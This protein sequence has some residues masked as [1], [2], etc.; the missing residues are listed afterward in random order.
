MR[1]RAAL[2]RHQRQVDA[3]SVR[4]AIAS[5]GCACF[6][7]SACTWPAWACSGSAF[8]W[9]AFWSRSRLYAVRMFAI[10][11]FYHRYFSHKAFRTSRPVQFVFAVLGAASVQRGP[12]WWA[13]HH[14]HHHRHADT[15][16]DIALAA[17]R[18]L[19]QPHGLVP[20]AAR[21]RHRSST[22]SRTWCE[23]PE[24]RL[25]DRFDIA[26]A[27]A[28]GRRPVRPGRLA[29][30][31]PRPRSAPTARSCWSGASSCPR[32]CCSMSR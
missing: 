11:G 15:E 24:L 29:G 8:S 7:S 2:V 3:G 16:H 32:S 27:G 21:L 9:F 20:D 22:R 10:T 18:L 1:G 12:L 28:A 31:A 6:P 19:A 25:L 23:F 13:A 30:A 4:R 14:R 5:T 26:G 17:A